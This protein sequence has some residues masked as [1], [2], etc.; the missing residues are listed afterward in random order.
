MI[1]N[2]CEMTCISQTTIISFSPRWHF[3]S[4]SYSVSIF[5]VYTK[6]L[7]ISERIKRQVKHYASVTMKHISCSHF[8]YFSRKLITSTRINGQYILKTENAI[9]KHFV[10]GY[11]ESVQMIGQTLKFNNVF[12]YISFQYICCDVGNIFFK[13]MSALLSIWK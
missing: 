8:T 6:V 11:N 9:C 3:K 13:I 5:K 12:V 7:E 2:K 1:L 4:F 10:K